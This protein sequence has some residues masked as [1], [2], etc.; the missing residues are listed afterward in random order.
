MKEIA[1]KDRSFQSWLKGKHQLL[2]K[3]VGAV[4]LAVEII[5]LLTHIYSGMSKVVLTQVLN[6]FFLIFIYYY[7]KD[8]F[9]K[10]YSVDA[11]DPRVARIL[12]FPEGADNK[13]TIRKL[14]FYSNILVSQLKNINYFI[15]STAVLYILLLAQTVL[16][17]KSSEAV[18]YAFH[19]ATDLISYAGA[20][21]LLR[22]FYVMYLPTIEGGK[23]VLREKTN[24]YILVG[25]FLM[26]FDVVITLKQQE[27]GIFISEFICGVVNAVVFVLLIAR[28]ENKLLDIPPWVLCLLYVYAIIQTCLPFVT[29][30]FLAKALGEQSQLKQLASGFGDLAVAFQDPSQ[31]QLVQSLAKELDEV[32]RG[33]VEL[34]HFLEEFGS[35]VLT[36]CLI[37]KVALSAVLLYV[38]NSRRIFYYFMTLRKIHEEEEEHWGEFE[39][40]I[41]E[42]PVKPELYSVVYCIGAN[43]NYIATIPHLFDDVTGEGRTAPEAKINLLEKIRRGNSS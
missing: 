4:V 14:D 38:L 40:L 15:L 20:F 36:L 1:T 26:V 18:Q 29:G 42:F 30:N 33:R 21:F 11:E 13:E 22:C 3:T 43:E 5:A 28:F 31:K 34:K 39:E 6:L 32:L 2:E 9:A 19:F 35:I 17:G 41:K 24:I 27:N 23:D 16:V 10:R 37:G 25:A 7:L 8:D 12:R